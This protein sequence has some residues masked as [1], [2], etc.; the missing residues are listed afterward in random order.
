MY[1]ANPDLGYR[2]VQE[3]LAISGRQL[4]DSAWQ[5]NGAT[6]WNG[7]G[8]HFSH[9][10]GYGLVAAHWGETSAGDWT[11]RI[12]DTNVGS[13]GTL[14]SFDLQ[15]LGSQAS[16]DDTYYFTDE[17]QEALIADTIGTDTLNLAAVR[18]DVTL[19]LTG[20]STSNIVV[21]ENLRLSNAS[22]IENAYLG[23]GDDTI[24]GNNS[25][26]SIFGGRGD[27]MIFA[28]NGDDMID[29]EAGYD[30]M[31]LSG[32]FSDYTVEFLDAVTVRF[33]D[34]LGGTGVDVATNVEN[35]I[36]NDD[37]L[38]LVELEVEVEEPAAVPSIII[39][40]DWDGNR[41]F[42]TSSVEETRNLTASELG[43][44]D[45]SGNL[46]YIDRGITDLD[47]DIL[48]PFAQDIESVT[49]IY[50]DALN[51]SLDGAKTT[52]IQLG[53]ATSSSVTLTNTMNGRVETG[54]GNDVITISLSELITPIST[55]NYRIIGNDGNDQITVTGTHSNSRVQAFGGTG[56]DDITVTV[57]G[58][59]FLYGGA[60]EDTI[61]GSAGN[62]RIEGE[63]GSDTINAGAG[64]DTV[65]GG[66]LNDI[67]HGDAGDDYLYG[68]DGSDILYGDAGDDNIRG[69]IGVDTLNGG[70]GN[71]VLY[72]QDGND[73]INGNEDR[74]Y[75]YGGSGDDTLNGGDGNDLIYGDAGNDIIDAGAGNDEVISGAD[76]DT[77]Q[78][79]SGRDRL[80]AGTGDD[81]IR[82]GD[83]QDVLHGQDGVD[84]LYGDGATDTL[85]GGN[86]DD[87]LIGGA[88]R[89]FL[90]GG[91]GAD[92]FTLDNMDVDRVRD[93]QIGDGDR[94]DISDL[95]TGFDPFSSDIN[96]FVEII[97]RGTT[98][99]DFYV[100]SDGAGNDFQQVGIV[101][102]NFT[103][104]TV[105]T[106]YTNGL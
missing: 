37:I 87:F 25:N 49:V 106:L 5:T 12:Q 81:T 98:R 88:G 64:D 94:I 17:F 72:G 101:F 90:Y 7:G 39:R 78:G 103:G 50:N 48:N 32:N 102:G 97:I 92:T 3:I 28:S 4:T 8:M 1:E 35:F 53:S 93:F 100:N 22:V 76:N 75:L 86:G 6:N 33:T 70:T 36:F 80:L 55:E 56:N 21:G 66:D 68:D 79:G 42:Y 91:G 71:D 26:N 13:T 65:Y 19:L 58:N 57:A 89:D 9:D 83:D 40:F 14:E 30:T 84:T 74:D 54:D 59:H 77:I 61:S 31:T 63:G 62:E 82:G 69:G 99:T 10:Y 41:S 43:V 60:G 11:L 29:G 73:L 2:D 16:D 45:A 52:N 15:F 24:T 67:I 47:L 27:D 85:F 20:G 46:V 51:F 44:T 23:D 104:Q 95:L 105:D 38:T 18:D 96:D 34:N